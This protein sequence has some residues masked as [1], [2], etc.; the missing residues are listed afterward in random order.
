MLEGQ[1]AQ[2]R[3]LPLRT[4]YRVELNTAAEVRGRF[5]FLRVPPFDNPGQC[6]N[7]K[8]VARL[9]G[10]AKAAGI[11]APLL[12]HAFTQVTPSD[13]VAAVSSFRTYAR[14]QTAVGVVV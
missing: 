6:G 4:I 1:F 10:T 9:D 12:S 13:R 7:S 8:Q 2:F 5:S 14:F 11:L 3:C